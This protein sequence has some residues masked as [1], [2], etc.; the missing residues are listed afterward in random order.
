MYIRLETETYADWMKK[1]LAEGETFVIFTKKD[2][3]QRKMRCTLKP[4]LLPE[5]PLTENK[6]ERKKS[7]KIIA[8]YDLD[9]GGWRSFNIDSVTYFGPLNTLAQDLMINTKLS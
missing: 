3:T 8:V 4:E 5:K 7:D 1:T 2:G 6:Q 9:A